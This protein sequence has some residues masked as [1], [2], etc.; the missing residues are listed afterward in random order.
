MTIHAIRVP[1]GVKSILAF[2][3]RSLA[4]YRICSHIWPDHSGQHGRSIGRSVGRSVSRINGV[5]GYWYKRGSSV[6][7][8]GAQRSPRSIDG[9]QAVIPGDRE[10]A[11]FDLSRTR[12]H[13]FHKPPSYFLSPLP[14]CG[15]NGWMWTTIASAVHKSA[16]IR[17]ATRAFTCATVENK[18]R[19]SSSNIFMRVDQLYTKGLNTYTHW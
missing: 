5:A 15:D 12:S 8:S 3:W 10:P 1:R 6:V 2:G 9:P 4:I 16:R 7:R 19:L 17:A 14:T 13:L 18:Q 11:G